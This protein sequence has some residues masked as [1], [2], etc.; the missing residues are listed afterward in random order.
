MSTLTNWPVAPLLERLFAAAE[1]NDP[2]VMA[3]WH[4]QGA[5]RRDPIS[6]RQRAEELSEAYLPISREVGRLLYVLARTRQPRTIIEFGTSFGISTIHLAAAVR[7]NGNHGRLITTE[8]S[9][10]KANHARQNLA[11]AGL[12]N[13]VEVREGDAFEM[14]RGEDDQSIDM[15]LLD[16]WKEL[17]LP[18]LKLLEPRLAPEALVIA[19]DLNIAAEA[20]QSYV[21]FALGRSSK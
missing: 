14:L 17:Y 12:S 20:L 7:D 2:T 4:A 6:S 19:D 13:I 9:A 5:D 18:L 8:L 10:S 1:Q 21:Q 15:L 11:E 16:G 3:K